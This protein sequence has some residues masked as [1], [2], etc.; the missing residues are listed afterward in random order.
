MF[1]AP[2]FLGLVLG[3]RHAADADH[4][5]TIATVIAGGSSRLADALRVAVFWG[6]GHSL[7]FFAIGLG[8]VVF[9]LHLPPVFEL[10]VEA[11]IALSLVLLGLAQ[12]GRLRRAGQSAQQPHAARPLALGF[13]HGL[14][15]SAAIALLALATI[16]SQALALLYLALFALGTLVG[17]V[18]ITLLFAWSLQLSPTRR[19]RQTLVVATGLASIACGTL[20]FG[21]L[22]LKN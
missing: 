10:A 21:E 3:V 12:L 11:A 7:T 17:M 18:L 22:L 9:E 14:A 2:L 15:G 8:I 6:L 1:T 4:V 20:I 13:M 19:V 5:A 16:D